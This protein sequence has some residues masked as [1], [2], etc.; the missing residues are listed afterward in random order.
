MADTTTVQGTQET[1]A[2]PAATTT[3]AA[4]TAFSWDAVQLSPETK[5]L[6]ADRKWENIDT[7]LNSYRN[8]EKLTG[9]P[10]DQIIKLP[11][12][13]DPKAW[14]AVYNRLGRPETADKYTIPVPEG[15]KGEFAGVAKTWFH[16]AGVSQSAATKLAERW[17]GYMAEQAKQMEAVQTEKNQASVADLKQT[18]G[19]EYDKKAQVVD[20]AADSFGMNQDQLS[21]LKQV[22]GPKGAMEFLYN[23]GS[24]VA[25]EERQPVGMSQ[26]GATAEM[27]PEQAQAK[28]AELRHDKD[29]SALFTSQDV[30][31]RIEARE[32]IARLSQIAYPGSTR[33]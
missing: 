5:Q 11:K 9:V 3:T 28:I 8:L 15:D 30:K 23:I 27:T 14:D 17:N 13:N 31:Q 7:A 10:A 1:T 12:D 33:L 18:W 26:T 21:A 25:T 24:K 29:F 20:R 6:V 19:A 32:K 22:L 2:Q 4:P 16:E